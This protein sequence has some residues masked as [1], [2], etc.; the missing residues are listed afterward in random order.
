MGIA[1]MARPP[2][3]SPRFAA[4]AP[5]LLGMLALAATAPSLADTCAPIRK[6]A[7]AYGKAER[8][9][10]KMSIA[11]RGET[12]RTEVLMSPEGMYIKAGDQWVRSPVAVKRKDLIDADKSTFSDCRQLGK[13]VVDGVPTMIY[14][15]TG[16][17]D[18][19]PAMNG[20]MWIG[21]ADDLP[22][23]MEGKMKDGDISQSIRYDVQAPKGGAV[24]IPGLNQLKGL[25]GK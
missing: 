17:A 22:R 20:R 23:R 4:K 14:E 12:H 25:F 3:R 10:V 9:S 5:L 19:Q 1:A 8:Y 7:E 16:Q 13:E 24:E 2:A 15:F 21:T 11:S 18:G 6:A